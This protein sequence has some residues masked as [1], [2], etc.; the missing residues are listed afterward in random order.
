M[1]EKRSI[2]VHLDAGRQGGS[3]LLAARALGGLLGADVTALYTVVPAAV[4]MSLLFTAGIANQALLDLDKSRL[5]KARQ[6]VESASA[7]PGVPIEWRQELEAPEYAFARHALYADLLVLGQHDRDQ[8]DTGVPP[9][10]VQAVL[11]D[12]GKPALVVPYIGV[13]A[14][15]FGSVFV[16]WKETRESAR[17]LAAALPVLRKAHTVQVALDTA[18][19]AHTD[20]LPGYLQRHCVQA[21]YHSM[22]F[23][24]GSQ[25]GELMLSMAA[26]FNADLMVMGC[27][28]HSRGRELVLGGASRTVLQSMTLPV[29]MAH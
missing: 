17:A 19:G 18:A 23:D 11:I 13:R 7:E 1:N 5:A 8:R 9:D 29:L 28:G 10:F 12:S 20:L 22:A 14:P 25:A 15:S 24:A 21:Q 4:E 16:A 27:Y 6:L 3:R 2:L 26:D